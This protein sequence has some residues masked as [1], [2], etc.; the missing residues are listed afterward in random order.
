MLARARIK[1]YEKDL[2]N[3]L[4]HLLLIN[5]SEIFFKQW[6]DEANHYIE[7]EKNLNELFK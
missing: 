1:L 5:D 4:K 2:E 6:I 3:A 7:F